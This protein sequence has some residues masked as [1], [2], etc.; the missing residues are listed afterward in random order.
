M[1]R[2]TLIPA[3]ALVAIL[4]F[5][6]V[7]DKIGMPDRVRAFGMLLFLSLPILALGEFAAF[8]YDLKKREGAFFSRAFAPRL[9]VH[10]I[11]CTAAAWVFVIIFNLPA[12]HL[13]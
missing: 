12:L 7:A 3:P 1:K 13:S 4:C 11:G 8:A 9:A 10:A 2:A 5:L 6:F